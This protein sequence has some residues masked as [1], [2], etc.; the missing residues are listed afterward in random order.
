M[1]LLF[2]SHFFS[3][4]GLVVKKVL[5]QAA[6]AERA[7]AFRG[8]DPSSAPH[9]H[10][11]DNTIGT[12]FYSTPHNGTWLPVLSQ[13]GL[14]T[15]VML[16]SHELI[17][18]QNQSKLRELNEEFHREVI[19]KRGVES[20]AFGEGIGTPIIHLNKTTQKIINWKVG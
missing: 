4:G 2:I 18:L 13:Q 16:P 15:Y 11:L 20:L 3:M 5:L 6:H 9:A 19:V 7:A 1:S 17:D 14:F 12:V 8:Q 10:I